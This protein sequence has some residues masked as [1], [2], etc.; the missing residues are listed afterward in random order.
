MDMAK[1][2][3]RFKG[4]QDDW[5][6]RKLG[7]LTEEL[8]EY[9]TMASG[10]PLLTSSRSGLMYQSD[11]RDR[12]T[13]TSDET[14][15]SIVPKG[16]CT[17]RHMSDDDIFHLNINVLEKGLVS[18]EYPVFISS[19]NNDLEFI[20][21]HINSSDRF[22]AFCKGQKKGGTRTRLYYKTLCEFEMMIPSIEEQKK[23]SA[24]LHSLDYLITLHQ[25]K[26]DE[27]KRLKKY[28]LQKMFPQN[29]EKVPEIRFSGFTDD[30]E[31]R[32]VT[33]LGEI[34]IGLVTTMTEHYTD[35]GHLLIR[36][37]DIKDGYFEFGENPIYLD[38]EFSEQNKSRMH[39][40]GDVITVHTGDIGT[41]AVIGENEVNSI[42]FATIVTRPNQ[43]ILDSNYFAT[44]LNTD[45]HKQW[46]ISMATGDGRSN[47]NLK[48][49]TKL[50]VPIPEIEEQ[51]KIATCIVNLN[52]LITLH[53][54]EL[55]NLQNIKKF[56][57][58]KM[59]V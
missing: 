13:T 57:L 34:Y 55:E 2:I 18:R 58:G 17:Y 10:L 26:C 1:P 30:W 39:Q 8:S 54:R 40:L 20:I 23:I 51:K 36:N 56:M 33:D 44:Y 43:E 22:R 41:S 12:K 24:T 32:K 11:F 52:S 3:I 21:Q 28:M 4:Y 5:E 45:T 6:Q 9:A 48:D 38:E 19:E 53:Q 42:G 27:T 15:F 7:D 14:L 16:S 59:F 25:R 50:V 29:G 46:A 35:K 37:S 31:Q 49:Y 47:Y